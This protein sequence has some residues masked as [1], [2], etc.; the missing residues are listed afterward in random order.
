LTMSSITRAYGGGG[1]AMATAAEPQKARTDDRNS[2]PQLSDG[3][4]A[5]ARTPPILAAAT[6]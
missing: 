3:S 6:S 1:G 4:L 2:R 5:R